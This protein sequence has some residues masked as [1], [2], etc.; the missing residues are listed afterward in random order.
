M[1]PFSISKAT[2]LVRTLDDGTQVYEA[3]LDPEWTVGSVPYGGYTLALVLN[4]AVNAQAKTEQPDP[5]SISCH[6]LRA[7]AL[8][9]AEIYVKTVRKGRQYTN[10]D[11]TVI[12]K[13]AKTTSASLIFGD[14]DAPTT[15]GLTLPISHRP[16]CPLTTH[17]SAAVDTPGH[18]FFNFRNY[19]RIAVDPYFLSANDTLFETRADGLQWGAWVEFNDKDEILSA[20][21]SG[22]FLDMAKQLTALMPKDHPLRVAEFWWLPTLS[23]SIEYQTKMPLKGQFASRTLGVV[24]RYRELNEGRWSNSVELWTA[25]C[26]IGE[27]SNDVEWREKM[28]CVARGGQLALIMSREKNDRYAA[29]RDIPSKL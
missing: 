3:N 20:D 23:M 27:S 2:K 6:F 10:L 13:N 7:L 18:P 17:P 15:P 5:I 9:T 14:I 25:P 1:S 19:F 8:S 24:S 22:I 16:L 4:A 28:V 12:Q 21:V 29:P 11:I 26:A